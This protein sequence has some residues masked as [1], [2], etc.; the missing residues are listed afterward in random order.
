MTRCT[1]PATAEPQEDG[2]HFIYGQQSPHAPDESPKALLL[3][4]QSTK[5]DP[6]QV[7]KS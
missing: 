4:L 1:P 3:K 6:S 7:P 2:Q 5:S